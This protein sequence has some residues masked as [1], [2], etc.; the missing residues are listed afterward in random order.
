MM[1]KAITIIL[2]AAVILSLAA[3]GGKKSDDLVG[4]WT[5]KAGGSTGFVTRFE[6]H[7]DGTGKVGSGSFSWTAENGNLTWESDEGDLNDKY[8]Y[9]L[10]GNTLTL[11]NSDGRMASFER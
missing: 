1:K 4:V 11:T 3:C 9:K 8:S 6:L 2:A 7:P 5:D 10:S